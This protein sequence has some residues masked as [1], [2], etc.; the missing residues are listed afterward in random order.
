MKKNINPISKGK[1]IFL[2]SLAVVSLL[3]AL[4]AGYLRIAY[5]NLE[6][7]P[8]GCFAALIGAWIFAKLHQKHLV[9]E[10]EKKK[11]ENIA[12]MYHEIEEK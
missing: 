7:T 9:S 10:E 2:I 4:F 3:F 12:D 6:I 1:K 5:K 11:N 8:F